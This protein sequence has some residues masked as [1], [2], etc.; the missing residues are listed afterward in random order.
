MRYKH[1]I[2]CAEKMMEDRT[3]NVL[4][5]DFA[6]AVAEVTGSPPKVTHESELSQ[7][8]YR[9]DLEMEL[10]HEG[11]SFRIVIEAKRSLFPRDAR[12]AIWQLRNYLTHSDSVG[13]SAVP[14]LIAETISP[15]ARQLLRDERVGYFDSSGSLFIPARKL[16]VFVDRPASKKQAR[17]LNNP[18]VGRRAQVLHAVWLLGRDWFGVHQIAERAGVSPATASETLI[19]I[20]RREWVDVRGAGPSKE[21]R[22]IKPRD[23]L[24]AWSSY[25]T[26]VKPKTL[27]HFYV[28]SITSP[29]LQR[30]I[31]HACERHKVL[32]EFAD[33]T[34]GQL[35]TPYLSSVSQVFCQIPTG[36]GT[37]TML[38]SIDARPV[39]EGWNLGVH[40]VAS[41]S[42]LRFRQR[43]D[44][45]WVTD[46]LQTY[47]D[48][49]QAGGRAKELA[50]HLRA[51][52]LEV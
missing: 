36:R 21:R 9:P 39:R 34:A 47:L 25:Q 27:R 12:E 37:Q 41:D 11:G 15:G 52:K 48:L 22:L 33:I 29:D 13:R 18:F 42:E 32:Y 50:Q 20:E 16:Y 2:H 43:I 14:V 6:A 46:P 31:D 5:E 23:L 1:K 3:I 19:S 4:V 35:H 45:A 28:P 8:A 17:S 51:E 44:D 7:M 38:D 24:D 30:R 49:L 10:E 40:E 26:S